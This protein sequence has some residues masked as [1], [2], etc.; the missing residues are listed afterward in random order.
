MVVRMYRS[1]FTGILCAT[2][3]LGGW[4]VLDRPLL[5]PFAL[6]EPPSTTNHS[7]NVVNFVHQA[8]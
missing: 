5:L 7:V 4:T 1:W 8:W 2:Y 6:S 3:A